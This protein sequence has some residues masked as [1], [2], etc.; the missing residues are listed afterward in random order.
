M[1]DEATDR[2]QLVAFN[3]GA[4]EYAVPVHLVE[5]IIPYGTPTNVPGA[6][7]HIIG[8]L[9]LRGK[10]ISVI[11]LRSRL[12][13]ES[14]T[15]PTNARILVVQACGATVG[16]LVDSV[17]EVFALDDETL[18]EPPPEVGRQNAGNISGIIRIDQRLIVVLDLERLLGEET[19]ALASA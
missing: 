14:L 18:H 11:D 7:E 6:G 1:Q 13:L 12:G 19:A 4:E 16:V 2:L 15:D 5:S 10:I 8:V 3:V 17:S 9:N